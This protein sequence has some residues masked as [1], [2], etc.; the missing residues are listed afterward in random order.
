MGRR[1]PPR[2]L[3]L[4]VEH[5]RPLKDPRIDR[6]K[7]HPLENILVMTLSASICGAEGWD[8]IARFTEAREEWY[9]TFLDMPGGTPSADTFR[10]LF[11]RLSP[12]KFQE[13]FRSW[14]AALAEDFAGEVVAID[15]KTLRGAVE[16]AGKKT[17]LHMVHV[18]ATTQNLLLAQRAVEGGASG[19]M[20]AIPKLL[21][22]LDLE[23][24]IITTD[25]NSCTAAVTRAIIEN[26]ADYVLAVKGNRGR[27]HDHVVNAFAERERFAADS[28]HTAIDEGH[29]R[30]E[31]R[32]VS[33]LE[34]KDW[35]W[36]TKNNGKWAGLRTAAR[37]ERTREVVGGETS[38]EVQFFVSSLPP[39]AKRIGEAIRAHWS[40]ENGLHWSLDVA[41]GDDRRRVRDARAAEN[42][43]TIDRIALMLLKHA[44]VRTE[45]KLS[46]RMSRKVAAWDVA[47][48][49]QVL[50][51]G[52]SIP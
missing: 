18:W 31:T 52:K 50:T 5:F 20:A 49:A 47:Y 48:T 37:I 36:K 43:A 25:A 23:G 26:K 27:F 11:E 29:G 8:E 13:C 35:P 33:V 1:W 24:A 19:E 10:R 45:R 22:V 2:S 3:E 41:F 16:K 32:V 44:P 17:Q 21:E 4:V 30:K 7:L 6:T 42:L 9:A 15:G 51:S 46:V 34:P 39:D 38:T 14:V 12:V 28:K 40:I